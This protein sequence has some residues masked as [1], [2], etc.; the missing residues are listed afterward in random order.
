MDLS[1]AGADFIGRGYENPA[2]K[3]YD[4]KAGKYYA[5]DDGYGYPTIGYGHLIL[6]GEDFKQ[7]LTA[8]QVQQ[9]FVT[10]A[11][12]KIK[13]VNRALTVGVSQNQFDAL[14]SLTFNI[15]GRSRP[16]RIL[17]A[18]GAV[19]AHDF[20]TYDHVTQNGKKVVSKGLLTRRKAEWTIFS[21]NVYNASH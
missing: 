16:I 8:A 11:S 6:A 12:D 9:L 14:V 5:Y 1:K 17:N 20:T 7:G 10:D 21:K 13:L 19:K 15:G 4:A 3:G 2:Q 18:G